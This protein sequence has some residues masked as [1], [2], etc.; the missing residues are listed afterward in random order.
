MPLRCCPGAMERANAKYFLKK[1]YFSPAHCRVVKWGS[2]N[3][4]ALKVLRPTSVASERMMMMAVDAPAAGSER[5]QT[6]FSSLH[7]HCILIGLK[8]TGSPSSSG[9]HPDF[10]PRPINQG[11]GRFIL[12]CLR[13][14][15]IIRSCFSCLALS[16]SPSPF[17]S[18]LFLR[19]VEAGGEHDWGRLG[20]TVPAH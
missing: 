14:P 8:W 20:R 17:L 4:A 11:L 19:P 15:T 7:R 18:V 9:A 1:K 10:R 16:L 6:K 13:P 12:R 5:Q 2:Q 3:R